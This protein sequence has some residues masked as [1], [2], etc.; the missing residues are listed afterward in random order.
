MEARGQEAE[1]PQGQQEKMGWEEHLV[2]SSQIF[3]SASHYE[4]F[5]HLG[6]KDLKAS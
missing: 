5:K 6:Q 2:N 3:W 1:F 4:K